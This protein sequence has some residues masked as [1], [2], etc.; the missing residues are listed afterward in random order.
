MSDKR[1]AAAPDTL[2]ALHA[3]VDA[4]L[5]PLD[6]LSDGEDTAELDELTRRLGERVEAWFDATVAA[7]RAAIGDS[8]P[9]AIDALEG[10]HDGAREMLKEMCALV[11][12][13]R[14]DLPV[15]REHLAASVAAARV[16][17]EEQ[18]HR[19][20]KKLWPRL[21]IEAA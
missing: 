14:E 1:A 7:A 10:D 15:D 9:K 16:A 17:L 8:D 4:L 13:A 5:E 12:D 21:G 6:D 2:P 11:K 18:M 19:E 3:R 20:R